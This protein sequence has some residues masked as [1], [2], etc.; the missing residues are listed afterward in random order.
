MKVENSLIEESI[1]RSHQNRQEI[2]KAI[3][4]FACWSHVVRKVGDIEGLCDTRGE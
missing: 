2:S 3:I 1:N 4:L